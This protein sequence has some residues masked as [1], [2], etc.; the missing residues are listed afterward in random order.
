M[1]PPSGQT[2]WGRE[3]NTGQG[4]C[5]LTCRM[6]VGHLCPLGLADSTCQ[7]YLLPWAC[8]GSL[9]STSLDVSKAAEEYPPSPV[10]QKRACP[11]FWPWHEAF[12]VLGIPLGNPPQPAGH[13]LPPCPTK[14]QERSLWGPHP[15]CPAFLGSLVLL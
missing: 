4:R 2:G 14:L 8:V 11:C 7:V 5:S 1:P 10:L 9:T 6:V 15:L 13:R 12:R 3:R